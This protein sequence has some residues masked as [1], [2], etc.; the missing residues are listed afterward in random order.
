MFAANQLCSDCGHQNIYVKNLKLCEWK[1][2]SFDIHHNW[3]IN[4][5]MKF[6]NEVIRPLTIGTTG[7]A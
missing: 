7:I 5:G 6:R 1:G 4:V 2:F 3:D